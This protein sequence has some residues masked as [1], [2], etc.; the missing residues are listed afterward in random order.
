MYRFR[1]IFG[2]VDIGVI[3]SMLYLTS[4]AP[5]FVPVFTADETGGDGSAS[6]LD[7]LTHPVNCMEIYVRRVYAHFVLNYA[8]NQSFTILAF[9]LCNI[10]ET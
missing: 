3:L 7:F 1:E 6:I 9:L 8:T 4:V 5:N 10:V 2:Y